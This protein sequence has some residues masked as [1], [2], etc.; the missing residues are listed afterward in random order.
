MDPGHVLDF[1]SSQGPGID[2]LKKALQCNSSRELGLAVV[3]SP[4]DS[5]SYVIMT[6]VVSLRRTTRVRM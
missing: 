5:L 1:V 4:Q 3:V 2:H 6:S